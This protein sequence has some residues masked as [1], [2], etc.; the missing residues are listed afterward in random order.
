MN[1]FS[2]Y[3]FKRPGLW[4]KNRLV[5][6]PMASQTAG[7]DGV[8]SARSVEHY[9]RLAR[10]GAGLVWVEYTAVHPSGRGEPLQTM[11]AD[12]A[13][14]EAFA[15]VAWTIR[16]AGVRA[17]LQLV[18]VGGKSTSE[19]ASFGGHGDLQGPSAVA[20]PVKGRE[21]E[22]PRAMT[23]RDLANWRDWFEQAADRAARAGFQWLELH[24][25]HGY[26]LNQ[27]LSPLTNR[28]ED[29][30]GG[31]IANR[32][33][34]LLEIAARLR[35]RHPRRGLAVRLPGQDHL[36]GGLTREESAW[37]ARELGRVG[38][39]L[40]DV[41]S[42][43]GGWRRTDLRE[44]EGYLVEDAAFVRARSDMPVIGVGGV[45]TGA[46][47]DQILSEGAVD[48]VAVGRAIL[49]DPERFQKTQ[50]E[51]SD[52]SHVFRIPALADGR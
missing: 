14:I 6:P 12:D 35:Q 22:T 50:M 42:G 10:S 20:V 51:V 19:L 38:V 17:G 5:V 30:Y 25:A 24:A 15:Q 23:E 32:A 39:D 45:K 13:C 2:P 40:I 11:L 4:L 18:H 26:G 52:E 7:A 47:M 31:P 34:L 27:F 33:R 44:D 8:P 48:L 3:H 36:A 41:S 29:A 21:L 43:L 16:Q 37:V 49:E 9:A 28:R 46:Y 1:R